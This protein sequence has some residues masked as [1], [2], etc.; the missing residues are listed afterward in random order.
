M[1]ARALGG[2]K[3]AEPFLAELLILEAIAGP[4]GET[5]TTRASDA[6]A[7]ARSCNR[8]DLETEALLA[9]FA[10]SG[11][12]DPS[13]AEL[14]LKTAE[15]A[16]DPILIGRSGYDVEERAKAYL[17]VGRTTKA[18]VYDPDELLKQVSQGL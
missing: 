1:Q 5:A 15:A 13:V 10:V 4:S 7:R 6:L 12:R 9:I 14:A 16:H 8:A 2:E 3:L 17:C 11:S 18:V